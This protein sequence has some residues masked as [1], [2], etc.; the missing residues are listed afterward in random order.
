MAEQDWLTKDFYGVLGVSKGADDKEISKAFRKLSR[1]YHPDLNPG[2]K[3][4]EEKYKEISEA[5]DVLSN[6][7]TRQKYDAIRSFGAG[8][9]RFTGGTGTAGGY[10]DML[11]AMFGNMGARGGAGFAGMNFGGINLDDLMAQA[12]AYGGHG[13]A[14]AADFGGQPRRRA[15]ANPF[16]AQP[17]PVRGEDRSAKVTLSLRKAVEGATI[18]LKVAGSSFKAKIPAGVR[19]GQTIRIPGKGK[20]GQYGGK[21]GDLLVKVSVKADDT[22]SMQGI[23]LVRSVPVTVAEA[24]LGTTIT[25]KDFNGND[26]RAKIPAGSTTGTQ[27][28]VKKAGVK[29]SKVHGD[30]VLRLEVQL[31]EKLSL[32][33]KKAIKAMDEAFGD[34]RTEIENKRAE[35]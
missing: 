32:A 34:F 16:A 4:A 23:D 7:D 24:A 30:L 25:V 12:G 35:R 26:V 27:V 17:E 14:G 22:F 19:D 9:A 15:N 28:R 10:E 21:N 2:D 8:G 6:K 31:P 29:T 20:S 18:S 5:Y 1:K 33:Q 3:K 13:A 11:G